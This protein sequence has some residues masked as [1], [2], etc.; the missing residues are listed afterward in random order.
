MK[1]RIFLV[2]VLALSMAVRAGGA[3][4]PE[5]RTRFDSKISPDRL[6]LV[7]TKVDRGPVIDGEVDKDLVWRNCG[8]THSAWSQLARNEPSGRQ[9]VVYSCYDRENLY[10]GFVCEE[11]ELQRVRMD[12]A[13]SQS[14]QPCGPDDCVEAII[15]V[16]GVQGDGEVYSFRAN[17]RAQLAGWGLMSIPVGPDYGYHVPVWK[18]TGKFGPNRWMLEMAIPFATIKKLPRNNSV[19]P[20]KGPPRGY[21]M[22]LKLVRWG[23]QQ[24]DARNR[25]I[26]TWNADIAVATPYIAG[27]NGLLY[28]EDANSLRDGGF[29]MVSGKEGSPW[30]A[31]GDVEAAKAQT[32]PAG[33]VALGKDA[34]IRQTVQVHGG[35]FYWL[36]VE[37]DGLPQS[38]QSLE[39]L[40]DGKRLEL[41]KGQAGFW[42][43]PGQDKATIAIRAAAAVTIRQALLQ[44]QPG[45][46]PP[47]PY[48]LTNNYR[49]ADRNLRA[50]S[51]A[52]PEGR[53]QYVMLDYKDQIVG[54]ANPSLRIEG[55]WNWAYDYNLRVEDVGGAKGWIPFGKGSLTGRPESVFWQTANPSDYACWG[56]RPRVVEVDLGGQYFVRDL[57]VLLPG[58]NILNLE[59]WGKLKED[60]NWTLLHMDNGQ[61]VDPAKRRRDRRSY[62][63][64]GGLDSVVRY[65]MWRVTQPV[66]TRD[67]PQMDGIQEFWVWGEPKGD[68]AGIKPFRPWVPNENAPP[69]KWTTTA[70]DPDAC[71]ILPRP[72]KM[73]KQDGWFV[74]GPRT[75]IVAQA[76]GEARQ[77]A[78]QIQDEIRERWQIDV[79]IEDEPQPGAAM[80]GVIYLGQ[81]RLGKLAE[82]VRKA[83]GLTIAQ[84]RPQAYAMRF[85]RKRV[86]I[87][88]GDGAGLYWGVQGMMLAM[89][90]HSSSDAA[91]NGLGVRCMMVEDWP[92]TLERSVFFTEGSFFGAIESEIPRL[93]RNA[94]LQSRFKLNAVYSALPEKGLPWPADQFREFCRQVRRQHHLELRP[95][96]LTP[97]AIHLG[98]WDKIVQAAKD[99]SVVERDQDEA[100]EELGSSL[101]LCPVKDRT[102]SIAFGQLD[103]L[104]DLYASPSKV[105]LNELVLHE[106]TTGSRWAVCRECRRSGKTKDELFAYFAQR[107]AEHLRSKGATGVIEPRNVAFGDRGD[108]R[109]RRAIVAADV[110][111]LPGDFTYILPD[112]LSPADPDLPQEVKDRLRPAVTADG[113]LE[114]PSAERLFRGPMGSDLGTIGKFGETYRLAGMI[115]TV[116]AMWH[117][118][119]KPPASGIDL[120]DLHAWANCWRFRRDLPSWRAGERPKF[121]PIDIRAFANH[122]SHPTG[123]ETL[124]AGR[125]QEIDLRYVP[126]GKQVLSG[127]EF[128]L[129]DPD[130]NNGKGVLMLGRPLPGVTHPKD[131]AGVAETAGPIPVGR[132]T[133]SLV[134]LRTSWQASTQ[135]LL[136]HH[137]WLLPCCRV[138]YD[139]DTWLAVDSF[140]VWDQCDFW[141]M[142]EYN[143]C[144]AGCPL[145]L[146]RVGWLG[147]CP[148]GSSVLLK[149]VEWVNPYPDKT[150]K[151]L[152]FVTPGYEGEQGQKRANPMCEAII[153]MTGVE[154]IEQDLNYW[155]KR[156]DKPPLL[157]PM[158]APRCPGAVMERASMSEAGRVGDKHLFNLKAP[159][160]E[161]AGGPSKAASTVASAPA[162]P[163]TPPAQVKC[164]VEPTAGA[165]FTLSGISRADCGMLLCNTSYK[166]FGM[167]QT[168][169]P[170]VKLCR[171]DIRGPSYGVDHEYSPGRTHRI[172]VALEISEDGQTWRKAG[173]LKGISGDCDFLSIEFEP[174]VVKMLRFRATA[175]PYHEDYPPGMAHP[176]AGPDYPHFVWRLVACRPQGP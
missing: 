11:P 146:E 139:D 84:D 36:S 77:I 87:L 115:R 4:A 137:R 99:F 106:P 19:L 98:G 67:F 40:L 71:Q 15:E 127:V 47:G 167:V 76:D 14:F 68:H 95:M 10:F 62:E 80:D 58:P 9:T 176:I 93:V 105:W 35:S 155:S 152:R 112:G 30:Q 20:P 122:V 158:R 52:A 104:L 82:E 150:V 56:R 144:F 23:A 163:K 69:K 169:E 57:D 81:P 31:Q 173:E 50:I 135:D 90:W 149:V 168:L 118:A 161:D 162:V 160:V 121:F 44:Y 157:P 88:G 130:Q 97:P 25:M 116:E 101:N 91:Q 159:V 153:A 26:S 85:S 141:N 65:L 5:F 131:A 28:F 1:K 7:C 129:I 12:G 60:D 110:R 6:T 55:E 148:G 59:I 170:A 46:K 51:P 72:R 92:V 172:D 38:P 142:N 33:G 114:H 64:V 156:M 74:I 124:E 113:P 100:P 126:A 73:T 83:E 34:A 136:R 94:H 17:S 37:A 138:I 145:L 171:V 174:A 13:L 63:S 49:H 147:N 123:A 108:P 151:A 154:P 29:A 48:C 2:F 16:G 21:V 120:Q 96:L 66:G 24:E 107:F 111:S 18:S 42:T 39:V 3:D 109:W 8:R 54:D 32:Q 103:E 175:E 27:F 41:K 75:R 89:R 79:P 132:K 86:V 78:K 53:Y 165:G 133:A 164:A 143:G 166:P 128:D 119:D 102:Y 125:V 61:F 70:P 22:G 134:F 117:G 45:E 140:R 43:A